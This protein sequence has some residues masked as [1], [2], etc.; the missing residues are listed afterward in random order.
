[1]LKEEGGECWLLWGIHW[2]FMRCDSENDYFKLNPPKRNFTQKC[3]NCEN[4]KQLSIKL[5]EREEQC[6]QLNQQIKFARQHR[7]HQKFNQI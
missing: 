4:Y 1:M 3:Q 2:L 6:Y 7:L 5:K